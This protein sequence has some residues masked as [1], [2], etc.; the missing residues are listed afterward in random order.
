MGRGGA[1]SGTKIRIAERRREAWELRKRGKSFQAIADELG[2]SKSSAERDIK[3]MLEELNQKTLESAAE[4]RA[5]DLAR[6]DDVLAAWY[7]LALREKLDSLK[8]ESSDTELSDVDAADAEAADDGSFKWSTE[9]L[10]AAMEL[11]VKEVTISKHA[12][13]IVFK[14]L[15]Q[16]AKLLGLY[17][18]EVALMTP[19]P[20]QVATD[21]SGLDEKSLDAIIRNLTAAIGA[22]RD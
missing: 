15:E 5:L 16:R 1:A 19:A 20:I 9:E 12:T 14:A 3:V 8:E 2:Y 13:D 11:A 10:A 21:I 17:R 7:G 22:G 18:Q 6:L 4:A